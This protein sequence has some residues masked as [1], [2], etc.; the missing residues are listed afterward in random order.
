MS[1][2]RMQALFCGMMLTVNTFLQLGCVDDSVAPVQFQLGHRVPSLDAE[3]LAHQVRGSRVVCV[4]VI[5]G[6]FESIIRPSGRVGFPDFL[7]PS[8]PDGCVT[9]KLWH[10]G[11]DVEQ[12]CAVQ[13]V[14]VLDTK[15][16]VFDTV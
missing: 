8:G 7:K 11:L 2:Y 16:P 4:G 10:I 9:V 13:N 12:R 6:L 5:A 14:H 15:D 1:S 3:Q